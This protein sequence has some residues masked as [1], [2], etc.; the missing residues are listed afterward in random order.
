M[1][2]TPHPAWGITHYENPAE[3]EACAALSGGECNCNYAYTLK[4]LMFFNNQ[5]PDPDQEF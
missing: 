3:G 1:E 4:K 2:N 5:G